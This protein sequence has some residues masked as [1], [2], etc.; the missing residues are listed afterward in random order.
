MNVKLEYEFEGE[1]YSYEVEVGGLDYYIYAGGA[2][3]GQKVSKEVEKALNTMFYELTDNETIEK[4]IREDEGF[5]DFLHD[6]YYDAAKD[7]YE[8]NSAD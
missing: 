8:D 7:E 1:S 6:R 3:G 4:A 2:I 5:M